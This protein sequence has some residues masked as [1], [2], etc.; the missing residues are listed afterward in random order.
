[1]ENFES[2]A[3]FVKERVLEFLK[4]NDVELVLKKS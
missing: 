4:K 1:M 2:R 3:T